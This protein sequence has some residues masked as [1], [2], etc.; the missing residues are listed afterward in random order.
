VL[1]RITTI[2]GEAVANIDEVH[3][4]RTFSSL[5]AQNV[6]VELVLQ[7]RNLAH[8]GEVIDRLHGAGFTA[9]AA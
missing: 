2:G 8:V 5:S 9:Q 3:H 7:T 1:A 4:Q 6:E